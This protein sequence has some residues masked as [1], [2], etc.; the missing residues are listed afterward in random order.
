MNYYFYVFFI[1]LYLFTHTYTFKEWTLLQ[2]FSNEQFYKLPFTLKHSREVRI[3]EEKNKWGVCVCCMKNKNIK[4]SET[5]RFSI[6][7]KFCFELCLFCLIQLQPPVL[8][9]TVNMVPR[10]FLMPLSYL[11][12]GL[13]CDWQLL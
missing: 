2:R 13:L 6:L 4:I 3:L 8:S 1:F 10:Q 7:F 5:H 12:F 11:L 9:N